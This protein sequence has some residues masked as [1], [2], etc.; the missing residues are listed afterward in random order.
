[1]SQQIPVLFIIPG[2]SAFGPQLTLE[3]LG[4]PYQ[5]GITTQEIRFS[6]TFRQ[7]NPT[8]KIGALKDGDFTIGENSAILFYLADK[9]PSKFFMPMANTKERALAYQ[10]LSYLSSTLHPAITP[11]LY[12]EYFVN[13]SMVEGFRLMAYQR[14]LATLEHINTELSKSDGYFLGSD[15]SIVDAQAYGLLRLIRKNELLG[16]DFVDMSK[17]KH[18]ERFLNKMEDLQSVKNAIAIENG[19]VSKII[20]SEFAGYFEF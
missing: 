1:M 3:W 11:N 9:Y 12:P 13:P 15:V 20:N 16:E 7:I 6:E 10:W 19:N 2:A 17:L 8:G 5:V 14:F 18:I 4:I